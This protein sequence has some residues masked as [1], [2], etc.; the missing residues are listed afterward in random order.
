ME[1]YD[2][3]FLTETHAISK[4][5]IQFPNFK[6]Y[7]YPDINC[8]YEYPRGG[9]CVLVKHEMKKF[10]RNVKLLMTDFVEIVFSNGVHL[11]NIYIPPLDSP[12]YNEQYVELMCSWFLEADQ[13]SMP[14][15]AMGDLN[16][17]LGD[18]STINEKFTY[19]SNEDKSMNENG[20]H[21]KEMLF[22]TSSALPLNHL[23]VTK[24]TV[25]FVHV[26]A[27]RYFWL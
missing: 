6:Q 27:L 16:A 14:L 11:I 13:N 8:N 26:T 15:I 20:K 1:R 4:G 5:V 17:R 25:H 3:I 18:L 22:N 2:I 10:I 12:Y 7:E 23:K 24:T 9:T 19:N 21:I